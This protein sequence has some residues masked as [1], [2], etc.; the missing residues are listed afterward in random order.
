VGPDKART[1]N[2]HTDPFHV[3]ASDD[4]EGTIDQKAYSGGNGDQNGG[5][6]GTETNGEECLFPADPR[7]RGPRLIRSCV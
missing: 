2:S 3:A 7:G 4:E 5:T 1:D 6:K